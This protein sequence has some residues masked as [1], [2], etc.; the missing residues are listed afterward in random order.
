M[1]HASILIIVFFLY[2]NVS[3]GQSGA[4][5][6][7]FNV[8]TGANGNVETISIQPDGKAIIAG[9]F[10]SYNN[11]TRGGIARLN[12]DGSLDST[13]N[14]GIGI[15]C[16]SNNT[17]NPQITTSTLQSDGK[18]IVGGLFNCYRGISVNCVAR[19]NP[20]GTL[21]TTFHIGSAFNGA[22]YCIAI[23]PN[24]KI[25]VGGSFSNYDGIM[26]N[27]I[28]R[29]NAD[30]SLDTTFNQSGAGANGTVQAIAVQPDGKIVV[31]GDFTYYNSTF[32]MRIVRLDTNGTIDGSFNPILGANKVIY[33]IALQ[34][35][36]EIWIAG[37]FTSYQAQTRNNIARLDPNGNLDA[38][39]NP[40]AATNAG[41]Q[42]DA[43][44]LTSSGKVLISGQFQT[45]NGDTMRNIALLN[46]SG[47][48]DFSF[49]SESGAVIGGNDIVSMAL[50]S[51][52][53]IIIGGYFNNYNNISRNRIARLYACN[54]PAPTSIYGD[55][56]TLCGGTIIY[57]INPVDSA[58]SYIWTLPAGWNGGSDSISIM[59]TSNGIGGVV[60]AEAYNDLCGA[61][62]PKND[63]IAQIVAP[64][65]PICLVTVDSQSTHNNIIWKKP[66][67]TL[68]DSFY[69]YREVTTNVYSKIAAVSYDSAGLYQD[70]GANP[71]STYYS[72]KISVLDT[73]GVESP[74]SPY[75]STIHLAN[76]GNG[77][78]LWNLYNI[79]NSSNPVISYNVYKDTYG[80]GNFVAIGL[81]PGTNTTFTDVNY[82]AFPNAAYVVDVNWGIYCGDFQD[83][84]TT[85][86][87][88]RH[89]SEPQGLIPGTNSETITLYPNPSTHK[90][91]TISYSPEVIVKSLQIFNALGQLV[92]IKTTGFPVTGS[93]YVELGLEPLSTGVYTVNIETADFWI[94]KKLV[95][96]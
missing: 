59:A 50:Q 6:L 80:N 12:T 9:S 28:A 95:I 14:S 92:L 42:I 63:T 44:L 73:C 60:S 21:D 23:Q 89:I 16:T 54:L 88:I 69:I 72:Y 15:G 62:V 45:F 35:D 24:G 79:E 47:A 56:T 96:R 75:H 53:K 18:L 1:K 29:V 70:Y 83:V 8:G 57:S 48:L 10:S 38:V 85:R 43:V 55:S 37:S 94:V 71:N 67:T 33:S 20:D 17:Y 68:I 74:L 77:N 26:Q 32:E 91:F 90:N 64:A 65:P 78:L 39:F 49:Q 19:I 30:G 25:I 3:N 31:G 40:L 81:V 46:D 86:S 11:I 51:D 87:N 66:H 13:F 4:L 22:V 82:N 93:Q 52:G 61:S 27:D 7:T 76:L 34:S 5:D 41:S 84:N 36:G 58:T 2:I